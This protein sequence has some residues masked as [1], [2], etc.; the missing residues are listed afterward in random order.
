VKNLFNE[1]DLE[2]LHVA[3]MTRDNE[4]KMH[5]FGVK[6]HDGFNIDQ[7]CCVDQNIQMT[8][9]LACDDKYF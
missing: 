6:L 2:H 9:K 4:G 3:A 1:L 7:L 8:A 5:S